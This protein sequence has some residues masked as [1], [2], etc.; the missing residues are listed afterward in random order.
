MWLTG[1]PCRMTLYCVV[2]KCCCLYEHTDDSKH[3]VEAVCLFWCTY[4]KNLESKSL[5]MHTYLAN[6]AN[7]HFLIFLCLTGF[8]VLQSAP[9]STNSISEQWLGSQ[10]LAKR[11]TQGWYN[12]QSESSNSSVIACCVKCQKGAFV[13]SSQRSSSHMKKTTEHVWNMQRGRGNTN[14]SSRCRWGPARCWCP[15]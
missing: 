5:Y 7:S 3:V 8:C 1:E 4:T 12:Q 15:W 6:K 14:L 10:P 2:A 11:P 13:G 9:N